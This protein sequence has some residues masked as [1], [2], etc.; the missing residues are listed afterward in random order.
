M[1]ANRHRAVDT[2]KLNERILNI[3]QHQR[4]L[5]AKS[6]KFKESS[7]RVKAKIVQLDEWASQ[8]EKNLKKSLSLRIAMWLLMMSCLK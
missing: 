8:R 4:E 1:R 3:E 5:R 2:T 7:D 6:G